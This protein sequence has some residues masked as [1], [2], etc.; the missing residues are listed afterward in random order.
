MRPT[1]FC[2]FG[3]FFTP[4]P[5]LTTPKIKILEKYKRTPGDIVL[6]MWTINEA[7]MMYG[8]WD[9]RRNVQSFFVILGHFCPLTFLTT[10]K[11]NIFK[12]MIKSL[13]TYHFTLGY[14]KL[15]S[16]NIWFL[17]YGHDRQNFFVILSHFL[18]LYP[19]NDQQNQ[20]FEKMK[21]NILEIGQG[22]KLFPSDRVS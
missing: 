8:S 4:L 12:K 9:I 16:Y 20:N 11:I 1:T 14:H 7:H 17:G 19:S 15:W 5:Y 21:K 6:H 2:H 13:E 3:A 22:K 18:F 10:R